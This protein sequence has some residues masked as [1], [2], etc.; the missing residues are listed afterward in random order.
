MYLWDCR[1]Q[2]SISTVSLFDGS[3]SLHLYISAL[4]RS[5]CSEVSYLN[6]FNKVS[7]VGA[8][9]KFLCKDRITLIGYAHP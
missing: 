4:I 6:L 5:L 7:F 1:R 8:E 2:R 3:L 9:P